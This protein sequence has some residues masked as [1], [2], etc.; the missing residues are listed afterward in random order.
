MSSRDRIIIVVMACVALAAAGLAS[1]LMRGPAPG[2]LEDAGWQPANVQRANLQLTYNPEV[3]KNMPADMALLYASLGSFRGLAVNYLWM[4]ATELKQ[5]GKFYEAMELSRMITKLNPRFTEVW[6]FHSWNMAFNISVATHTERE[7]WMWVKAGIELLRDQGIPANPKAT[8]LYRQLAWTYLFKIGGFTDDMHWYYKRKLA[9]H[10]HELL[11]APPAGDP[12]QTLEWFKPISEM[13]RQ[14]FRTDALPIEVHDRLGDLVVEY[15]ETELEE[16]LESLRYLTPEQFTRRIDEVIAQVSERREDLIEQLKELKQRNADQVKRS[17][18]D[19]DERFLEKYPEAAERVQWLRGMDLELNSELAHRLGRLMI[20]PVEPEAPANPGADAKLSDWLAER[21]TEAARVRDEIVLPY[22]RAKVI[23][24]AEKMSASTMYELM[25]GEWLSTPESPGAVKLPLD[26][27]HPAAHGLYWSVRGVRAAQSRRH[28]T[29]RQ[30]NVLLNTDRQMLHALQALTHNGYVVFNPRTNYY[31]QLPDPTYIAAY[32]K[33]RFGAG[34]RIG[35]PYE[36]ASV[37]ESFEAGHENYLVWATRLAYHWGTR[38]QAERWYGKLGELFGAK[39]GRT[40][41]YAQPLSE[42]VFEDLKEDITSPDDARRIIGGLLRQAIMEGYINGRPDVASRRLD[43]ARRLHAFYQSKQGR[44]T[45]Q[46][47]KD[48]MTMPPF[49]DIVANVFETFMLLDPS[50]MP[51]EARRRVWREMGRDNPALQ[52]R[53]WPR[54][55]ERLY[56]QVRRAMPEGPPP[57]KLFPPPDG[58]EER[59]QSSSPSS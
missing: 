37:I 8:G 2:P 55:H 38:E 44:K 32:H 49:G 13:D 48:R 47:S 18:R 21:D 42:F 50:R 29:D 27:R 23:R 19:P 56:G 7:R 11:G 53:I 14:F 24:R 9:E 52:R 54:I 31:E 51:I 43:D 30:Y 58:V 57:E 28:K 6:I 4:R 41:K 5:Q 40:D 39:L 35:G 36:R 34:E 3:T 45:L 33:A 12:A 22:L 1:V 25:T 10:W 20:E 16:P 46:A 26:W 15:R 17:L 59:T